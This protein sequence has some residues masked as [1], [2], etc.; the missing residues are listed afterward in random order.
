M[1]YTRRGPPFLGLPVDLWLPHLCWLQILFFRMSSSPCPTGCPRLYICGLA[2][3]SALDD[4]RPASA[5]STHPAPTS[6][7]GS[8]KVNSI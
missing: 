7:S 2:H 5:S 1:F 3:S 8:S 4:M 6:E